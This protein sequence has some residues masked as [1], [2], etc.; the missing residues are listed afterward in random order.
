MLA[1]FKKKKIPKL[2]FDGVWK[3]NAPVGIDNFLKVKRDKGE[4]KPEKIEGFVGINDKRELKPTLWIQRNIE[5]DIP[6]YNYLSLFKILEQ[7]GHKIITFPNAN[8]IP[9]PPD[10]NFLIE[11]CP[12]TK[13]KDDELIVEIIA[14]RARIK[15]KQFTKKIDD[16]VKEAKQIPM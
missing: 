9:P 7:N 13:F 2:V 8:E 4:G 10:V 12:Y 16:I 11:N 5:T 14:R 3:Q 15:K 1:N 6:T